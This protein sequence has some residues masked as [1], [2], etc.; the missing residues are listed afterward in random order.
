MTFLN[1]DVVVTLLP[2]CLTSPTTPPLHLTTPHYTSLHLTT[3]HY[4]DASSRAQVNFRKAVMMKMGL[5]NA[6][7]VI[8][9]ISKCCFFFPFRFFHTN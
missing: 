8:W 7:H 5:N 2:T 4:N 6:R 3:P 1:P 9:T